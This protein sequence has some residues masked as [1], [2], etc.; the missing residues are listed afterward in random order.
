MKFCPSPGADKV[1]AFKI[2]KNRMGECPPIQNLHFEGKT[3]TIRSMTPE[4][5]GEFELNKVAYDEVMAEKRKGK[6]R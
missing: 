3:G 5:Y 1:I 2:A 6:F 4:E